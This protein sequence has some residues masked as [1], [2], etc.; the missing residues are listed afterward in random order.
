MLNNQY[1]QITK[2]ITLQS[3]S[4]N[5]MIKIIQKI[6]FSVKVSLSG[7]LYFQSQHSGG[8]NLECVDTSHAEGSQ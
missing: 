4:L 6:M 8:V 5:R 2:P 1:L 7:A 3:H